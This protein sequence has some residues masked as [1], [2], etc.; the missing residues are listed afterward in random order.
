MGDLGANPRKAE[1]VKK[2]DASSFEPNNLRVLS[3]LRDRGLAVVVAFFIVLALAS[4]PFVSSIRDSLGLNQRALLVS[5]AFVH[6]GHVDE[7]LIPGEFVQVAV[8]ISKPTLFSWSASWP[9]TFHIVA[10]L[11]STF[12]VKGPG[13]YF[14]DIPLDNAR[15]SAWLTVK[16]HGVALPL[17]AWI[18]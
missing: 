4:V 10:H 16:V 8:N 1:S 7:G 12:R 15:D 3:G 9:S 11:D 14:I 5:A 13:I 17:R 18:K 6:P 2:T